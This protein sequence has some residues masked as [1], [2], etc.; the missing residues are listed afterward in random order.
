MVFS[1][2]VINGHR[3][4]AGASLVLL[5]QYYV[6]SLRFSRIQVRN[7]MFLGLIVVI[8]GVI[9][10]VT[11]PNMAVYTA[12]FNDFVTSE[13]GRTINSGRQVLWPVVWQAIVEHP[14]LGMGPGTIV[15]DVYTT[16][17]S[18][19]NLYLQ[20]G[21]Q[22]GYVGFGLLLL[23]FWSLWRAARPIGL[24]TTRNLENL[25]TV[26][27]TMVIVH[28]LFDVFLLQNA[29]AVGI[30]VWI[31]LGLGLG[32]LARDASSLYVLRSGRG[33]LLA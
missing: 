2:S 1:L 28:S 23:L 12:V 8:T 3:T 18:A 5:I 30:P 10:L 11:N 22:L 27:V 9:A 19:H 7:L 4:L 16:T 6:L 26:V 24:P 29:L 33:E 15:G 31:V 32:T 25:M 21:L 14:L 20:I 13:G 17:L